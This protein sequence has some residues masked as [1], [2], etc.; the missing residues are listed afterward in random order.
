MRPNRVP[1]T[2]AHSTPHPP[3]ETASPDGAEGEWL[4]RVFREHYESLCAFVY[5]YT[6]SD[7]LAEDIVQDVFLSIWKD[8][9]R[10]VS[11]DRVRVL[12]F[13]AAR[14]RAV[15]H[16]RHLRVRERHVQRTIAEG[17]T[18][19]APRADDALAHKEVQEALDEAVASL[20]DRAREIFLLSREQGLTYREIAERLGISIKTVET[21]IG[22]SLKRLRAQL[23]RF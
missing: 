23:G 19:M 20:P 12:L 22:R 18:R 9:E 3:K 8:P 4:E 15:D 16:L 21:Q 17:P 13:V 11:A 7:D 1:M 14:N 10:W 6:G 2:E 5:S